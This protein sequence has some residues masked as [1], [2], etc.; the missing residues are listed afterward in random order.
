VA[1]LLLAAAL[2]GGVALALR[3]ED[4]APLYARLATG[5]ALGLVLE[6]LLGYVAASWLGLGNASLLLASLALLLPALLLPRRRWRALAPGRQR[7]ASA[8]YA[9]ALAA[10]LFLVF[11]RA[12]YETQEGIYTGIEHNVGDL[13]FHLGIV[14]GFTQA[15]NFPP[16]HPEL[17]SVRLTYPFLADFGVAQLVAAGMQPR[18]AMLIHN[19]LLA[20]SLFGLLHRFSRQV[21]GDAL[22]AA[23]APPL[24]FLA[25]GLGFV[26]LWE[27]SVGR[28][29]SLIALLQH[30]PH[31]YTITGSGGL[32]F[33]NPLIC[34]LT[35]QRSLLFGA[36]LVLVVLGWFWRAAAP[37]PGTAPR[38]PL[39][40]AAG[41]VAGLLPLVHA[42]SLAVLI[43]VAAA[44]ALLFPPRADWL[45]FFAASLLV[46]MPQALWLAIGS[47]TQA[48][49]F[50]AWQPGWDSGERNLA[51]FWL[52]NA[53]VF[54][55]AL[56]YGC[57]RTAPLPLVRFHLPFW[58]LFLAS[59]LLR[60]SPW[61]WDNIKFLFFWLLASTP[62]VALVVA[63]LL[64]RTGAARTGGA[65]LLL[66][67]VLSGGI[68]LW[69]VVSRQIRVRIF[70][71]EAIAFAA[72]L[73]RATPQRALV[74]RAPTYDAPALLAG[75][76]A[77]LGYAGHV[78]S[79]G[80]AAG[81]REKDV[82]KI[83]A[84]AKD[85]LLLLRW[86]AVEFVQIG[87]Q[88]RELEG[89]DESFLEQFPVVLRSGPYEL[90]RVV[91]R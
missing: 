68:D 44:L 71:R 64:R 42:H 76:R 59:N 15:A 37:G 38:R 52:V 67:L 89:F 60:L 29:A 28:G 87:P 31:D 16:E 24:L 61:I 48:G 86:Y 56:L 65:L 3:D 54:I 40:T 43:A 30:L 90:R 82:K 73:V 81:D 11:E 55:P 14:A 33:G 57:W 9:L 17:S 72:E 75:R 13:P 26:R 41:A 47:A 84:G 23:L 19:L 39:L 20:L 34:L 66:L 78:W 63:R 91:L 46:A 27:E 79:Q 83:Y 22:A 80:L 5:A 50:L 12:F 45:R 7:P 36:P 6:A 2:V 74:L 85:A 25:G 49:G 70:D 18:A 69:R 62:I 53:G 88:E 51:W 4:E 32:R 1:L 10:L 35:T 21:T 58:A 77:V 8:A